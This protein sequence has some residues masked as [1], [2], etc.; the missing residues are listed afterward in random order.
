M[1]TVA[2]VT[3]NASPSAPMVEAIWAITI[4]TAGL[5]PEIVPRYPPA[6]A[7]TKQAAKFPNSTKPTPSEEYG[8]SSPENMKLPNAIWATSSPRPEVKPADSAGTALADMAS[9]R[10][11]EAR[12]R[13]EDT[14]V[15]TLSGRNSRPRHT[16]FHTP[17]PSANT[18]DGRTH[19]RKSFLLT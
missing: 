9:A 14:N 10:S 11:S 13:N 17:A 8:D 16:P 4:T 2:V 5:S 7:M 1:N 15:T 18:H 12:L 19:H 6:R 3:N